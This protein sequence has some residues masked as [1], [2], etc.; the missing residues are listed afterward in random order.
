MK[1]QLFKILCVRFKCDYTLVTAVCV[2][3]KFVNRVAV[4]CAEVNIAFVFTEIQNIA[5]SLV[6]AVVTGEAR[7]P[8]RGLATVGQHGLYEVEQAVTRGFRASHHWLV[9]ATSVSRTI[10]TSAARTEP[11]AEKKKPASALLHDDEYAGPARH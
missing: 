3:Q 8:S 9:S 5:E 7:K 1:F 10:M 11:R 2:V 6:L 4:V